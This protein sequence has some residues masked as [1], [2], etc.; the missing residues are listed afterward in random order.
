MDRI[1]SE[2]C[3]HGILHCC[4]HIMRPLHPRFTDESL[5]LRSFRVNAS[6]RSPSLKASSLKLPSPPS[7]RRVVEPTLEDLISHPDIISFDMGLPQ[8]YVQ[9]L[10]LHHPQSLIRSIPVRL[11]FQNLPRAMLTQSKSASP[12]PHSRPLFLP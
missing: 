6:P 12:P 2:G 10:H 1:L 8:T 3:S 7:N 9:P 5:S 4:I 11:R